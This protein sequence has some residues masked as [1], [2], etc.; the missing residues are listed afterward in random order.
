MLEECVCGVVVVV[1]RMVQIKKIVDRE[2]VRVG[3]CRRHGKAE[4]VEKEEGRMDE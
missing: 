2:R 1:A 4:L 3:P